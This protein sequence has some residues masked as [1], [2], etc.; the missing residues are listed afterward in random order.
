MKLK[1]KRN[2]KI[3]NFRSKR[4]IFVITS[5]FK[6]KKLLFLKKKGVKI[7]YIN[8]LQEKHDF[9][10]LF[11][12]LKKNGFNRILVESGLVFLSQLLKKKVI[13]NLF[14]FKS[15]DRLGKNGFNKMPIIW[16]KRLKSLYKIKV[17]LNGDQ[18]YKIRLK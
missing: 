10:N 4:K 15:T 2:L 7:I 17:N 14:L 9:I 13:S 11:K 8:S 6:D 16:N 5:V 12:I 1:I 18:L 3:F